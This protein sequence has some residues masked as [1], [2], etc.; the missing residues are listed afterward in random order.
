M[1]IFNP[2]QIILNPLNASLLQRPRGRA[3][4]TLT[5]LANSPVLDY[6][7]PELSIWQT[8]DVRQKQTLENIDAYM[9]QETELILKRVRSICSKLTLIDSA[10]FDIKLQGSGTNNVSLI[11]GTFE[12]KEKLTKLINQDSW[13]AG[14]FNWLCPNYKAL[15]HSQELITFSHAYEKNRQQA[16]QQYQHFDQSE[17]GM[18]CYLA[19]T[20]EK[21]EAA[22]TWCLQSPK[23][24]YILKELQY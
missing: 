10:S 1:S 23:T 17:H 12:A 2:T 13:L 24:V 15:A 11:T 5:T 14:A 8:S 18:S 19:C 16:L 4:V 9:L 22:L 3:L 7:L 20:I 6:L 21:G